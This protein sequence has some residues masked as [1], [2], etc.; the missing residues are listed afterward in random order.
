MSTRRVFGKER[1]D[2]QTTEHEELRKNGRCPECEE[3]LVTE[4]YEMVCTR[5]G[6]VV[7]ER[8]VKL[9]PTYQLK[10]VKKEA[11][12]RGLETTSPYMLDENGSPFQDAPLGVTFPTRRADWKFDAKGNPLSNGSYRRWDDIRHRQ[13]RHVVESIDNWKTDALQDIK[14]MGRSSGVPRHARVRA[15]DLFRDALDARLAGGRMAFESLAAGS[16]VV[17]ARDHGCQH[18]IDDI[19]MWAR[20]PHERAC[21]GARK[22]RLGL[23]LVDVTPP[24]RQDAVE[25]VVVEMVGSGRVDGNLTRY[26]ALAEQLMQAADRAKIGS[27]T[28]R[29]TVAGAAVHR[30]G[31]M[32]GYDPRN[33]GPNAKAVTA[34]VQELVDTSRGKIDGYSREVRDAYHGEGGE[35]AD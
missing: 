32:L 35:A 28:P 14:T 27:G 20:T 34:A 8:F 9:G 31:L 17:A 5:C 7:E 18:L 11:D 33:G 22:I 25:N 24:T 30:A 29:A 23:D 19:V 2:E 10:H 26:K 15:T 12:K 13:V 3:Q 16:L 4:E 1:S 6:I 21:A